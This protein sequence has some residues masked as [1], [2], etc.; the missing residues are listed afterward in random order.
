MLTDRHSALLGQLIRFGLTGGL[1]TILVAGGYWVVATFLGVEP[2]LSLTLNYLWVMGLGYFIHSRW[3]FRG[4]GSRDRPHVRTVRFFIVNAL[5]FVIDQ[6]F[7]WLL[8]KKLGGPTWWPVLPIVF[9]RPLLTFALN[10]RWV[11]A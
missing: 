7:V 4:H 8:V 1:L 10:R 9:V 2:M 3:S 5:G 11:F 6:F